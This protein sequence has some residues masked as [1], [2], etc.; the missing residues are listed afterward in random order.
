[1]LNDVD[2]ARES[3]MIDARRSFAFPSKSLI[4]KARKSMEN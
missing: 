3:Q 1:M 4:E 2:F